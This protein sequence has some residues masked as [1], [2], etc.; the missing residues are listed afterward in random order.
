MSG[1][2]E[3]VIATGVVRVDARVDDELDGLL[4]K[5]ADFSE[6]LPAHR[7]K[8]GVNED[9]GVVADLDGEIGAGAD[10]HMNAALNVEQL[11]VGFFGAGNLTGAR[12][13]EANSSGDGDCRD[14]NRAREVG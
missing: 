6:S 8:A 2:R 12:G 7:R 3:V 5:R 1:L 10:E 4:R 13:C 9:D 14:Q 11:E